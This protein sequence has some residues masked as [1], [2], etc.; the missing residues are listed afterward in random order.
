MNKLLKTV[1]CTLIVFII[2]KN[3]GL[4]YPKPRPMI[5]FGCGNSRSRSGHLTCPIIKPGIGDRRSLV[6][7]GEV[8]T[9]NVYNLLAPGVRLDLEKIMPKILTDNRKFAIIRFIVVQSSRVI[10]I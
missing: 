6:G 5:G 8:P 10:P 9:F 3:K 2:N 1:H 7:W 4:K